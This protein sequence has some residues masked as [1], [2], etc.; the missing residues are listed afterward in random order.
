M[1][2]YVFKGLVHCDHNWKHGSTQADMV[3]EKYLIVLYLDP[4]TAGRER[5]CACFLKLKVQLQ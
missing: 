1:V 3:L 2:T 5:H 4:Q